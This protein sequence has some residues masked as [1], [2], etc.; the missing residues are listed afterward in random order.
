[1]TVYFLLYLS[2]SSIYFEIYFSSITQH[3]TT[4]TQT[5]TYIRKKSYLVQTLAKARQH[6]AKQAIADKSVLVC[7]CP[8]RVQEVNE[9]PR[10]QSSISG[11]FTYMFI[12]LF[13]HHIR[14]NKLTAASFIPPIHAATRATRLIHFVFLTCRICMLVR[15]ERT[16]KNLNNKKINLLIKQTKESFTL[17]DDFI[18]A[19]NTRCRC[20]KKKHY[21]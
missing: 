12:F 11:H 18:W 2:S 10:V 19:S 3:N 17:D 9:S 15:R 6:T 4:H 5:P 14:R 13:I 8:R 16:K 20:V 21:F 1:M 7:V